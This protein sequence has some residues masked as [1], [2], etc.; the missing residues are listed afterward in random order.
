MRRLIFTLLMVVFTGMTVRAARAFSEPFSITQP[1]GTTLVITLNGDEHF[2]WLTASDGTLLV[3]QGKGYYVAAI[4]DG[5]ELSATTVLAHQ[6]G[7]R[8]AAEQQACQKQLQRRELFHQ[9]ADN[10]LQAARRAQVTSTGYLPH[11][12]SPKCLIILVNFADVTFSSDDPVAQFEQYFNGKTQQNLGHNEQENIVSV[13]KYF[14]QSSHGMFTPQF[15]IVGPVT[16]P[17]NLAYYGANTSSFTRGSDARFNQFCQDA[18][19]AVD[20]LV[21]FKQYDNQGLN[22][23]ELV[24]VIYAGY[25]E[26]VIENPSNTLWPKCSYQGFVTDDAIT[27]NYMNCSPEL[28]RMSKGSDINGIGSFCHEFSHGMGL[29]DLYATVPSAQINN[30]TPE[31]WDLMDYGG[32]A[33]NGYAPAP[34]TAWEQE[35]M[36]WIDVEE[37]TGSRSSIALTPLM[38]GGKA[39]KFSNGANSEEWMMIENVQSFDYDSRTLGFRYGH[40]LLVTHLAY[41]S[42]TVNMGDY[43][44]NTANKPR[45]SI[46]PADGLV[47]NGYQFGDGKPYTQAEYTNNMG[48]DPFPGTGNVTELNADLAL[49]NYKFYNGEETPV[50]KLKNIVED[51][52]TGIVTFDFDDGTTTITAVKEEQSDDTDN[53]YYT[54]DGRRLDGQPTTRGLY[55]HNGKKV[56]VPKH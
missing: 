54:L 45:V 33:R 36:G 41:S 27:V 24:C 52:T 29:P 55:I 2:A 51:T 31:F 56:V 23:A 14:E 7:E 21:D 38:K 48:G 15:D 37:L 42:A 47:I 19:K 12:G 34:F 35:V 39:Y 32:H 1:D 10:T 28:F 44:N 13:R 18:I 49:P 22:R 30:Q 40:G 26:H 16:L 25:G 17:K 11:T 43:P 8:N 50:F 4:G 20:G 46:V 5:G 53:G 6:P 9:Y 3:E